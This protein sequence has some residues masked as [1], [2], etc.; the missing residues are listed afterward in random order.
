MS[1]RSADKG[2]RNFSRK[3]PGNTS[4]NTIRFD[5]FVLNANQTGSFYISCTRG[6]LFLW[7]TTTI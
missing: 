2:W 1:P 7:V 6:N 5:L 4:M 3:E